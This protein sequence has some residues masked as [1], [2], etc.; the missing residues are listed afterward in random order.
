[1]PIHEPAAPTTPSLDAIELRSPCPASWDAMKGNDRVRFCGQ[2][3]LNVYNISAMSPEEAE[4]LIAETEGRLCVRFFRGP[5]GT[6]LTRDCSGPRLARARRRLA[7]AAGVAA[8]MFGQAVALV[9]GSAHVSGRDNGAIPRIDL[10]GMTRRARRS[11]STMPLVGRFISP[12]LSPLMGAVAVMGDIAIAP[13]P[14][15]PVP[16][17]PQPDDE[18]LGRV[19]LG[20]IAPPA[21]RT[22]PEAP[23]DSA[24]RIE[25]G[26]VFAPPVARN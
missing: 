17:P 20:K 1:M 11:L 13:P 19:M 3:R 12:P 6:V 8:L 23:V 5:D 16:A 7:V 22:E 4:T 10:D 9:S 14:P 24:C 15:A 18:L 21:A 26:E 25:M 2:C